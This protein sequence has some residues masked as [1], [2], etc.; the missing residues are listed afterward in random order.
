M[1]TKPSDNIPATGPLLR[2]ME[3]AQ[4][5]GFQSRGHYY[6]LARQGRV[7]SPIHVGSRAAG[8]PRAWLD[9]CIAAAA[10]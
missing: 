5:L 4:Y 3:A 10:A 1:I 2:P 9:A 6:A 7:P 8:I